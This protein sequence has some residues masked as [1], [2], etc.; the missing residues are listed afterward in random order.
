MTNSRAVAHKS[1]MVDAFLSLRVLAE[2]INKNIFPSD[3][4]VTFIVK[5]FCLIICI[6]HKIVFCLLVVPDVLKIA[7]ST[8]D[9]FYNG[10]ALYNRI[11]L[12]NR[13][14]TSLV[15]FIFTG[16]TFGVFDIIYF[17]LALKALDIGRFSWWICCKTEIRPKVLSLK[18]SNFSKFY[19]NPLK[20]CTCRET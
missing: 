14:I 15:L 19:P 4:A 8:I 10:I 13:I 11:M 7:F 18:S 16:V 6:F 20:L 3:T 1:W 2:A 12:S 17:R 5:W 9:L